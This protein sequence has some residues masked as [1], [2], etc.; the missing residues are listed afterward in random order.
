MVMY[1]YWYRPTMTE[2]MEQMKQQIVAKM[3]ET[4]KFAIL[5]IA[6]DDVIVSDS[7]KMLYKT[8]VENHNKKIIEDPY[9]NAGFDL[10]VLEKTGF[11]TY[12]KTV[13]IDHGIKSEMVYYDPVIHKFE[14]TAFT[15]TPRSSISKTPLMMANHVGIIDA[16]YRGNLLGAL[17]YLPGYTENV[18]IVEAYTRLFQVCHPSLCPIYVVIVS[19]SELST[20]SRG[21]GGFGSTGV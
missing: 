19:E 12:Y 9:P 17:R 6:F 15:M 3:Q 16:G 10:L 8:H 7:I 11:E 21:S 2:H 18:Y 1:G 20:T 4:T 13:F 14:P 5:K